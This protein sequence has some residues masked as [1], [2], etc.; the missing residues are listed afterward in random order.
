MLLNESFGA[1]ELS[2]FALSSHIMAPATAAFRQESP[3]SRSSIHSLCSVPH[4]MNP[5]LYSRKRQLCTE[6]DSEVTFTLQPPPKRRK[7]EETPKHKTPHLFWENLPRLWLT[8]RSL[9]EF[10]Q[11]TAALSSS[12][13]PSISNICELAEDHT[14]Q[15]KLFAQ[16]GGPDLS[17]LRS[18]C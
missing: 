7:Q 4:D 8:P 9:R 13:T 10:D 1:S 11:R 3:L 17:D 6:V 5:A 12:P 18:V 2:Y 14:E 16:N 15:L